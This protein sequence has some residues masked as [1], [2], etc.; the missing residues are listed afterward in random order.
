MMGQGTYRYQVMPFGLKN[1]GA[2][3][4]KKA[5][6]LDTQCEE[7]FI[8]LKAYL[9]SSSVLVSPSE[10]KLLTFYLVVSDFSTSTALVRERDRIQQ[11]VYYCSQALR[12]AEERY[13]KMEKLILVLVTTAEGF[14]HISRLT[15]SKSQQNTQ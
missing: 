15:P 12:G 8:E 3:Y 14:D 7:A 6:H 9:S 1:A 13:P 4:L 5:F 11:P 2:T 10:R